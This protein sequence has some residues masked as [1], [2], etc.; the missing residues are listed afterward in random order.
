MNDTNNIVAQVCDLLK[1]KT[2]KIVVSPKKMLTKTMLAL[3]ETEHNTIYLKNKT[4]DLDMI[5]TIAHELRHVWQL[6]PENK[7]RFFNN[8]KERTEIDL[9]EYNKQLPEVDA[10]AFASITIIELFQCMPLYKGMD[11]EIV[12]LIKTRIQEIYK[13]MNS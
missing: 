5:F 4:I 2:P 10:N 11:Q 8:Y 1:I 3:Y 6:K 12:K 13:E 7:N 9:L